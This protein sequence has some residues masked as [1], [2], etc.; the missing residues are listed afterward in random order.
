M[1]S[2]KIKRLL[3]YDPETGLFKWIVKRKG[4]S[5]D[6]RAG[7]ENGNGYRQITI[8]GKIYLEHRLAWLYMTGEWPE[9]E[10][11]HENGTPNDNRWV[12]LRP[13][14]S[15]QGKANTRG[16]KSKNHDL[17]RGV[18]RHKGK[19]QAQSS[20]NGNTVYLG[21]YETVSE[22]KKAYDDYVN[23][24]FGEYTYEK[25]RKLYSGYF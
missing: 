15:S 8:D 23:K 14:T 21:C 4:T 6:K 3:F 1:Q 25:S 24:I 18:T 10:I 16:T 12:N 11:D 20:L 17:P 9:H 5:K 7:T 19:Y 22:A 2:E 13:S